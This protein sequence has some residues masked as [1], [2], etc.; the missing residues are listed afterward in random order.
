MSEILFL[1]HRVPYPPTKG[2]KIRS[3]H[4]LSGL[5]RR[6]TVH[7]GSFVDD[8]A[9]WSDLDAL[10]AVCGELC[11]R[12]IERRSALARGLTGLLH[13][14]P[15]TT[16]Y[17]RDRALGDW[18]RALAARRPLDAVFVYSSSMAQYADGPSLAI[19]GPRV[20]DF[21]DVDSDKWRQYAE[22]HAPPARWVYA[23]EA[24]LVERCERRATLAFDAALVSAAVQLLS[25]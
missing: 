12:P 6:C 7:L 21:C 14:A 3:W 17:Y 15:V 25:R 13:G 5:A 4:L 1:S 24:R 9:D 23:R 2:D 11:L 16:G 20:I 19:D 22:S 18:V 10:R 8:P